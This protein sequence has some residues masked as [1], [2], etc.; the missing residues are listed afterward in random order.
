MDLL[1]FLLSLIVIYVSAWLFGGLTVRLGQS[2]VLGEMFA[3]VIVGGSVLGLVHETETLKL[4]GEIGVMLLLFEVGLESDLQSFLKVG[5]SAAVVALIGVVAPFALGYLLAL[6]MGLHQIQAIFVG[7]TLTATSIAISA[8]VLSDLGRLKSPEGHIILGAAVLDDILGLITLS[9]VVGLAVSGTVSW[10]EAGRT[11]GL[12]VFLLSLAIFAGVRYA[13]LLSRFLSVLRTRGSLVV[14]AVTFALLL[15]YLAGRIHLAP[16]IGAFA[17]G[18]VLARTEHQVHIQEAITPVANVFVPIFFVLIG[19][20]MNLGL[21]NPFH[22]QNRPILL[23]AFALGIVAVLGKLVAGLGV[24]GGKSGADPW[25]VGIGMLPRG[26]VGMIFASVGLSQRI[27][28]EGEYGA[29][30]LVV[31]F[32]TLLAPILLKLR[33]RRVRQPAAAKS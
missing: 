15:G 8:R 5:R 22:Q 29:I 1:D 17:A 21:L 10:M 12:A 9:V 14:A 7:A 16:L 20:A 6:A 23:L 32:T 25:T 19:A 26:E 27:I 3:G 28:G 2:A 33:Y 11:A 24:L 31:A 30:L 4:L 18:L 13:P